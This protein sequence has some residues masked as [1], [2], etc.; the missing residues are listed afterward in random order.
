MPAWIDLPETE[1]VAR[2]IA[3]ES[4]LVLGR[5]YGVTPATVG[6]RLKEAGVEMRPSCFQPG[7]AYGLGNKNAKRPGGPLSDDGQGYLRTRDR[8]NKPCRVHRGCWEAYNGPVPKGHLVH[9]KNENRAD[10]RIENLA[11]MTQSEH[12]RL[13]KGGEAAWQL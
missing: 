12:Q 7:H 11:C 13:H 3:G 2:Y 6:R 5:A 10:C 1:M 9:H 4:T 8:E